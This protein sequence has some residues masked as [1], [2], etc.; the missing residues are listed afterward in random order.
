[1]T[2]A[3]SDLEPSTVGT[4]A[5]GRCARGSADISEAVPVPVRE[6]V[7]VGATPALARTTTWQ[8]RT[9]PAFYVWEVRQA[10]QQN[11]LRRRR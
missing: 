7:A 8:M 6:Q 5:L 10:R 3:R 2:L 9:L 11:T 1:M 4:Q